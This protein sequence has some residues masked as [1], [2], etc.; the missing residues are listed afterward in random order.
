MTIAEL[1]LANYS[2]V[3]YDLRHEAHI[4]SKIDQGLSLPSART[5]IK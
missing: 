2:T 1:Q 4:P 3:I 5:L